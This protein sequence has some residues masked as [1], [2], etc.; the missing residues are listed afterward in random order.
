[1][2]TTAVAGAM[3]QGQQQL[4]LE[5]PTTAMMRGVGLPAEGGGVGGNQNDRNNTDEDQSFV[6]TV[7]RIVKRVALEEGHEQSPE[8]KQQNKRQR[9]S[10]KGQVVSSATLKRLQGPLSQSEIHELSFLCTLG[11]T[12]SS[13]NNNS[14]AHGNGATVAAAA[15]QQQQDDDDNNNS[16]NYLLEE[17]EQLHG[18][19]AVE[20]DEL[21][22][23]VTILKR[24]VT[25]ADSVQLIHDAISI[26]NHHSHGQQSRKATQELDAVS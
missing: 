22:E 26:M 15:A 11:S 5:S 9:I 13:Y 25:I 18:F 14:N 4:G 17:Q 24:H 6:N 10:E 21:A 3:V 19:A 23:I 2:A 16:N 7:S 20:G 1:M 12:L 8:Q